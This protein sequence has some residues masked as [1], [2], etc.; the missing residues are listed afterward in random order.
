MGSDNKRK[1]SHWSAATQLAAGAFAGVVNTVVFHPLDLV[2]TRL[3]VQRHLL[4][5]SSTSCTAVNNAIRSV[6][7][8]AY[9]GT[10]SAFRSIWRQE[11]FR[12][13]YR[14]LDAA[15][16][17]F[18]PN[19]AI[20]WLSYEQLKSFLLTSRFVNGA[21]AASNKPPGNGG[22]N[23]RRVLDDR[24]LHFVHLASAVG[25]GAVTVCATSPLW[26]IKTRMQVERSTFGQTRRY[27]SVASSVRAIVQNEGFAALYKGL[28]P[29]L[30]GLLHVAVQFP[31][32]E[33]IKD[34]LEPK[35]SP[36]KH[37]GDVSRFEHAARQ[38][39]ASVLLASSV[40]KIAASMVAYPHEVVRSRLQA[41]PSKRTLLEELPAV[42]RLA[43]SIYSKEGLAAFYS[44]MGVNLM[45]AVPSCM[46]TFSCYEF[47]KRRFSPNEIVSLEETAHNVEMGLEQEG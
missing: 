33:K 46:L 15:L 17:A 24:G 44:G 32:Y 39:A 37:A 16:L 35:V 43:R 40:S 4:Q 27:A 26:V 11:G 42:V 12:A 8:A 21:H 18:V 23:A 13:F 25:A 36:A 1:G 45:R 14:G 9:N 29:S 47:A 38:R 19:W 7:S 30:F 41:D 3:Q 10:Y 28:L 22:S 31:L 5:A 20:Y 6:N 2:K 34:G